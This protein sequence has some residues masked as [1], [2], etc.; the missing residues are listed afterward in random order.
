MGTQ[1]CPPNASREKSCYYDRCLFTRSGFSREGPRSSRQTAHQKKKV[2]L[3]IRA[4]QKPPPNMRYNVVWKTTT[5][6]S[7][8]TKNDAQARDRT[9]RMSCCFELPYLST[10]DTHTPPVVTEHPR[11]RLDK[12]RKALGEPPRPSTH[13]SGIKRIAVKTQQQPKSGDN[14]ARFFS[15]STYHYTDDNHTHNGKYLAREYITRC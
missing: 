9:C 7:D 4:T 10:T 8:R 1:E 14:F 11:L 6:A 3:T 2:L 12:T 15:P 13:R 5:G